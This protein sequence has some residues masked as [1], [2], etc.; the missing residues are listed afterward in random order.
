MIWTWKAQLAPWPGLSPL[1]DSLYFARAPRRHEVKTA[2]VTGWDAVPGWYRQ[3]PIH[4]DS[5]GAF[6]P[7][8]VDE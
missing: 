7:Y 5:P 2:T 1:H 3:W 4:P 6:V 8:E